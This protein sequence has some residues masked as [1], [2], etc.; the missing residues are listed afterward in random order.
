MTVQWSRIAAAEIVLLA[1]GW[2]SVEP[3]LRGLP[4]WNGRILIDTTYPFL[5]PAPLL[6]MPDLGGR[7][8]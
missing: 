1:V 7:T 4:P 2:E 8:A 5:D 3:V 6:V